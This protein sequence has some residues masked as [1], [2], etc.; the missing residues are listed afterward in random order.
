MTFQ[1]QNQNFL[2]MWLQYHNS[3]YCSLRFN[4]T[5]SKPIDCQFEIFGFLKHRL[6]DIRSLKFECY[7]IE[8]KF[9][10]VSP[11]E[12]SQLDNFRKFLNIREYKN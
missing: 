1:E 8:R 3:F 7:N 2:L 6:E 4:F 10:L 5:A 12:F 11:E 9:I